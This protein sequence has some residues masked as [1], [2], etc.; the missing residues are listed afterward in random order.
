MCT[1]IETFCRLGRC[2]VYMATKTSILSLMVALA[3]VA[4]LGTTGAAENHTSET[5]T[6]YRAQKQRIAER[7]LELAEQWRGSSLT[8][9]QTAQLSGELVSSLA[10]LADYWVGSSWGRGIPQSDTPQEGKINCGTFV[11]T[12]LRDIGFQVN[13]KKLQRQP[14]QG[15]IRSFVSGNR[16]RKLSGSSMKRFMASLK[17]MGPGLFIIGLHQ[18]V[19]LLIQSDTEVL[20]L[21]SSIETGK[22]AIEPAASAWTITSSNYRVVGK[23]LSARNLRDW[24]RGNVIVVKG[25]KS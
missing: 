19:G 14:S 12:L 8:P 6:R 23:I 11:G 7:R 24:L 20:Y 1:E 25:K 15:I 2:Y 10:Q 18:H 16:V 13:I 21:H 9:D 4:G 17:E 22:V 3:L 5:A